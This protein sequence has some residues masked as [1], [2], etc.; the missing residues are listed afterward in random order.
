MNNDDE[1]KSEMRPLESE[2]VRETEPKKESSGKW[3]LLIITVFM[4]GL[5]FFFYFNNLPRRFS[6]S[7]P[8]PLPI[9]SV[10]DDNLIILKTIDF[11]EPLKKYWKEHDFN[12]ETS[13]EVQNGILHALSHGNSSMIYQEVH[14]DL[15]DRPFLTWEWKAVQFPTNKKG[16]GLTAKSDN[17]FAGRVYVIFKGKNPIAADV[18]QYVWDDHYPEGTSSDSPFLKNVR[19]IVVQSGKSDEWV[20]EKRDILSD[21]HTFFGRSPRWPLSAI[22]IMSDSDNTKTQSEIFFRNLSIKKPKSA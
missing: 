14:I 20:S 21:Y 6:P 1:S 15:K 16:K 22:G 11:K 12:S 10:H 13:Y 19:I 3:I 18:I 7:F 8:A 9:Q 5:G 17:D 4:L 2:V